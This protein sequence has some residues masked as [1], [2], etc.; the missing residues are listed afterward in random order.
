VNATSSTTV[1]KLLNVLAD[2]RDFKKT[3]ENL[4]AFDAH[5]LLHDFRMTSILLKQKIGTKVK[6]EAAS[7]L[8]ILNFVSWVLNTCV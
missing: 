3:D 2:L 8:G 6:D 7:D 5:E 1:Q 4:E